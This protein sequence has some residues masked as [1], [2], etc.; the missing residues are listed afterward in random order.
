MIKVE[1]WPVVTPDFIGFGRT[2]AKV[3]E[4]SVGFQDSGNIS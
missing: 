3:L 4:T 2:R 1:I